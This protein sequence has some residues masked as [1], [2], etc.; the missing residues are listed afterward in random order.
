MLARL[1]RRILG[2]FFYVPC[3]FTK[4]EWDSQYSAGRWDL[5]KRADEFAHNNMIAGYCRRYG[6]SRSVIDLCCGE[7]VLQETF[8]AGAYERYLGVDISEEAIRRAKSRETPGTS[9]VC[10]N[11]AT[12]APAQRFDAI[13][14]NE[15][16]Y[17][18]DAPLE[19]IKRYEAYLNDTGIF[20]VSMYVEKQTHRIWKMLDTAYAIEDAVKVTSRSGISWIVKVLRPRRHSTA[21]IAVA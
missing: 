3:R 19:V 8:G 2:L 13:V 4:R 20:V 16:L 18:F 17:Y 9:F 11:I 21:G 10:D 6:A 14:F 1:K 7:G 12:F 5:L 15:C